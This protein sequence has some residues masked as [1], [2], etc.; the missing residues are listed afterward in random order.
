MEL[1][2]PCTGWAVGKFPSHA[3]THIRCTCSIQRDRLW[4]QTS[5]QRETTLVLIPTGSLPSS[6]IF[7]VLFND[8]QESHNQQWGYVFIVFY[9]LTSM[10]SPHLILQSFFPLNVCSGIS[11]VP[12]ISFIYSQPWSMSTHWIVS[13]P[14]P[15]S[16]DDYFYSFPVNSSCYFCLGCASCCHTD[17]SAQVWGLYNVHPLGCNEFGCS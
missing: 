10:I 3:L 6:S 12:S 9:G 1:S 13:F 11:G 8:V 16:Y 15:H 17:H 14:I 4:S 5:R 7:M 2:S